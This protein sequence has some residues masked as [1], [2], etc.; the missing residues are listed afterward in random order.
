MILPSAQFSS[1]HFEDG[2]VPLSGDVGLF[3]DEQLDD[4]SASLDDGL[5]LLEG[6]VDERTPV[7]L[8]DQRPHLNTC[9][10][11][12]GDWEGTTFGKNRFKTINSCL[13]LSGTV[14]QSLCLY[15]DIAYRFSVDETIGLS[16][17]PSFLLVYI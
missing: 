4:I 6:G 2:F 1:R 10:R 9:L 7:P 12:C 5:R 15:V 14:S 8:Q 3:L 11:L 17:F 16:I 13:F